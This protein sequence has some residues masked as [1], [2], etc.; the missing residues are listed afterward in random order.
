MYEMLTRL[1]VEEFG[2]DEDQVRPD[3]TARQLELDSL[4]LAELA[5]IITE[6][7]GVRLEDVEMSPDSTLGQMAAEFDRARPRPRPPRRRPARPA[8]RP[9]PRPPHPIRPGPRPPHRRSTR[10]C[11]SRLPSREGR[12]RR[13]GPGSGHARRDRCGGRL[14]RPP[15][16]GCRRPPATRCWPDCGWT[17]PAGYRT[18]TPTRSSDG[19]WRAGWTGTHNSAWS[20]PARPWPW[21]GSPTGTGTRSASEW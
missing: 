12:C 15:S 2:L 14:A 11:S 3:A 21:R 9:R 7:T 16:P 18:S 6:S 20:P 17:S 5:V 8:R 13:D 1:L 4:S 10:L 19:V